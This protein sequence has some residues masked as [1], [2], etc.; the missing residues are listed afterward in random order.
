[1]NTRTTGTRKDSTTIL[2]GSQSSSINDGLIL[3][4]S[5]METFPHIAYLFGNMLNLE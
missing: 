2:V 4:I 5:K 1:M 3:S